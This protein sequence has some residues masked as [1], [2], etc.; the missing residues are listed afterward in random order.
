MVDPITLAIGAKV[1][2]DGVA[3]GLGSLWGKKR[4]KVPPQLAEISAAVLK[5]AK[6]LP[7]APAALGQIAQ[8]LRQGVDLWDLPPAQ[9]EEFARVAQGGAQ[10]VAAGTDRLRGATNQS[11][12]KLAQMGLAYGNIADGAAANAYA[13]AGAARELYDDRYR[14]VEERAADDALLAG[15]DYER[16]QRAGHAGDT[17]ER[18]L[19]IAQAQGIDASRLRGAGVSSADAIIDPSATASGADLIARNAYNAGEEERRLGFAMRQGLTPHAAS[20][21]ARGITYDAQGNQL[22]GTAQNLRSQ[23]IN[24]AHGV[25]QNEA[26]SYGAAQQLASAGQNLALVPWQAGNIYRT[27]QQNSRGLAFDAFNSAHD[28]DLRTANTRTGIYNTAFGMYDTKFDRDTARWAG[29][30]NDL[31]QGIQSIGKSLVSAAGQF[32]GASGGGITPN[33]HAANGFG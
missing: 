4:P 5:L 14:S 31:R 32:P 30:T 10:T 1:A 33:P 22:A 27:N 24:A 13:D 2:G 20:V 23:G 12:D 17:A 21:A 3:G 29:R 15:S 26:A 16:A 8:Q 7:N 28:A 19:A 18:A 25:R 9:L 6:D 11:A